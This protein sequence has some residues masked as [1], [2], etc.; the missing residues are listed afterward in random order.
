MAPAL[1]DGTELA[2]WLTLVLDRQVGDDP[3]TAESRRLAATL[4]LA[5]LEATDADPKVIA[6]IRQKFLLVHPDLFA[7]VH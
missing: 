5:A 4:M 7:A 1:L 3:D 6:S 2:S